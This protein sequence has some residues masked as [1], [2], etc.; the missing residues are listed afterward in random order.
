MSEH[1][2]SISGG[3]QPIS[4][5]PLFPVIVA[6]WFGALVGLAGL[7]LPALLLERAVTALN[8]ARI[9]P[10]AAPPLGSTARI[11]VTAGM[12]G[13]GGIVGL[14]V[15]LRLARRSRDG[16]ETSQ[17]SDEQPDT[18]FGTSAESGKAS[19]RDRPPAGRRRSLAP[20]E[21]TTVSEEDAPREPQILNVAEFDLADFVETGEPANSSAPEHLDNRLFEAYARGT[22]PSSA[23]NDL[24]SA[25]ETGRD[26]APASADMTS[27]IPVA[28]GDN[29]PERD[30]PSAAARIAGATLEELS[31][32]ELL[33]RLALAM[34][35]RR[36]AA[37]TT[38]TLTIPIEPE[39]ES[40]PEPDGE[41][42]KQAID[43]APPPFAMPR[44]NAVRHPDPAPVRQDDASFVP[45]R[46]PA[47]LRPVD[48]AAFEGEGEDALPGYIPPRHIGGKMAGL[49]DR[50]IAAE[51]AD[52][53]EDEREAGELERGYSSLL[54]LSR[55]DRQKP[56]HEMSVNEP[57]PAMPMSR[58]SS[59]R[60]FDAPGAGRSGKPDPEAAEKALR[61]ALATL[62][63]M[64]GAA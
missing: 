63:R 54:D 3:D 23:I 29:A 11:L 41:S 58:P 9:I 37:R 19:R 12:M 35:R 20:A 7:A 28:E 51:A 45:P 22:A 2:R 36:E 31:P 4:R 55:T 39:T 25:K 44:F 24:S 10:M 64:S 43:A 38:P 16:L 59:D 27:F 56:A 33:E 30:R 52:S 8:I 61:E 40:A 15:A 1:K 48:P 46:V 18:V 49:A 50:A 21:E 5:H 13:L 6:L 53:D 26:D 42:G 47:A 17:Q 34:E 14:L 62:Q 32:I 57:G 60:P